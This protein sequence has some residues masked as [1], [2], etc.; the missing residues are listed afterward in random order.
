VQSAQALSG[1]DQ[2]E[3][4]KEGG[5]NGMLAAFLC[6]DGFAT[7]GGVLAASPQDKLHHL[8]GGLAKDL[9][10]YIIASVDAY[11]QRREL[12]CQTVARALELWTE[13]LQVQLAIHVNA[14]TRSCCSQSLRD[15]F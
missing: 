12:V 3:A 1:N 5:Y 15:I 4:L 9:M 13:R 7:E 8:K 10:G 2:R 14:V 6:Y 11:A